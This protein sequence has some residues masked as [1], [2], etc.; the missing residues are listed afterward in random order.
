MAWTPGVFTQTAICKALLEQQKLF[1]TARM[2]ELTREIVAGQAI[3]SHQDPIIIP[4]GFGTDCINAKIWTHRANSFDTGSTT[5]ACAITASEE[6]GT[7]ALDVTKSRLVNNEAWVIDDGMCLNES[8]FVQQLAYSFARAKAS[9]EQ[10]LSK[11]LVAIAAAGADTPVAGWFETAG[12]VNGNAYEVNAEAL[13][14]GTKTANLIAD[15][16]YSARI[17]GLVSPIII[18]GRNFFN[19]AI[20]SEFESNGCCTNDKILTG[21]SN[22]NL[23]WDVQN[24]DQVAGD[25]TSLILDKNALYF[26]SSPAYANM[27]FESMMTEGKE[28]SDRYHFVDTLPRLKYFANGQY[29]D[30]YV[31]VRA[32]RSCINTGL[33]PRNSWKF[34]MM[35]H[36]AAGLNLADANGKNGIVKIKVIPADGN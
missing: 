11:A 15:L 35:L 8:S 21:N 13:D 7:E 22:L 3:L 32:E 18:N 6:L 19:R 14:G 25:R 24:V 12:S 20:L 31:D 28:A 33:V 23:F 2:P 34:T 17:N 29:N 9:M 1:E 30:I 27:G 26:W 5:V 4:E 10:K 36:G 16:L